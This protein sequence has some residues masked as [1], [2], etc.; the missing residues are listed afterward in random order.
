MATTPSR[1]TAKR[2]LTVGLRWLL[3]VASG[4]VF[5]AGV[6][7]FIGTEQTD[8]YFAW[9]IMPPLT[10]ASLGAAYWASFVLEFLALARYAPAV[11]WGRP[12]AWG[13]LLFLVSV[14]AVGLLGWLGAGVPRVAR[15]EPSAPEPIR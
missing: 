15:Q 8:L 11:D 12:G 3:L 1:V 5:L 7:L 6:Q 2:P 10:A 14:L 4:L 13:Y 9:T